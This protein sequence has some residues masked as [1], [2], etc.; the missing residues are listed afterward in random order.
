[1]SVDA[2][3]KFALAPDTVLDRFQ[4]LRLLGE[5]GM[6]SVYLARDSVLGR[7][8]DVSWGDTIP[9][10]PEPAPT[11][12]ETPAGGEPRTAGRAAET[13]GENA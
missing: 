2:T 6:G 9:A 13:G 1:M 12:A 7:M 5:G 4:I 8:G 10:E 11:G 3:E